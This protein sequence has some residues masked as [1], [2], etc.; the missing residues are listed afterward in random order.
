M[1]VNYLEG[2]LSYYNLIGNF[3]CVQ[4]TWV[5]DTKLPVQSVGFDNLTT[6]RGSG[7]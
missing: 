2:L 1:A 3:S 7:T 6:E 4:F 5:L